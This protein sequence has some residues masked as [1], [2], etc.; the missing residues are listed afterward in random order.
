M[1]KALD[2]LDGDEAITPLGQVL[3]DLPIDAVLG[4]MLIMS[5]VGNQARW[6][7]LYIYYL[8]KFDLLDLPPC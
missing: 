2:A 5:S 8:P 7:L 1:L 3:A 6:H 4:K